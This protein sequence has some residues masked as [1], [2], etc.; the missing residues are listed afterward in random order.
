MNSFWDLPLMSDMGA[1]SVL[2]FLVGYKVGHHKQFL[3]FWIPN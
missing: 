3:T 2:S 1:L